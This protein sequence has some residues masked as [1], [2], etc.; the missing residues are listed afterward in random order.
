VNRWLSKVRAAMRVPG[1]VWLGAIQ[2]LPGALGYKLRF[3]FWR[4]RLKHLGDGVKIEQGVYF[5]GP[6]H[7]SIGANCWIDRGVMI[8][9][10]P[11][12]SRRAKKR[13]RSKPMAQPGEVEIGRNV[14]IGPYSIISGI[15]AGVY[16]G[17]DCAFSSGVKVFAFSHHYR[18]EDRPE[19]ASCSF[20]PMV[21]HSRQSM[22]CGPV[23]LEGNVGVALNA[24]I[25]PGVFVGRDSFV[26]AN[27]LLFARQF[28]ANSIISGMPAKRRGARFGETDSAETGA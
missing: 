18:F 16:I 10:G 26:G 14:H 25:L 12:D 22:I 3:A 8:A 11:D 17:D 24:V 7:I 2:N 23:A 28:R 21:E 4:R 15:D 5:Q 6:A 27:S 9:A 19:D 1:D 20:G 13:I